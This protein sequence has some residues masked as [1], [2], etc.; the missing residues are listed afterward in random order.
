MARVFHV[1]A[2]SGRSGQRRATTAGRPAPALGPGRPRRHRRRLP[3]PAPAA[4]GVRGEPAAERAALDAAAG[5]CCAGGTRSCAAGCARHA[6]GRAGGARAALDHDGRP[7]R[8]L[9][10]AT[11]AGCPSSRSSR[12]CSATTTTSAPTSPW[13]RRS[14]QEADAR[15][16]GHQRA[17]RRR[18]PRRLRDDRRAAPGQP[19][20]GHPGR[21]AVGQ[22]QPVLLLRRRARRDGGARRRHRPGDRAHRPA[23]G[24]AGVEL[25]VAP[26]LGRR[27]GAARGHG[28]ASARSTTRSTRATWSCCRPSARAR[29]RGCATAIPEHIA[30]TQ[31]ETK[32][33]SLTWLLAAMGWPDVAGD[34]LAYGTVIATGNAVV[35]WVA[36]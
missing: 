12:T 8:Q 35:E 27:A 34:V 18:R 17:A 32:A 28:G 33:G 3:G 6:P 11:R 15:R 29:P 36:P 16:A 25:A 14:S 5:R 13:P 19:G 22:Q 26:A 23:R 10:A 20:L 24:A 30:A 1:T 31:A 21:V 7:P 9:R 4:P 2:G